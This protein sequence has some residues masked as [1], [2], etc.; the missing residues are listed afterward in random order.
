MSS[1]LYSNKPYLFKGDARELI[2]NKIEDNL[3]DLLITSP[4]YLNSRDYTDTY[5][6]ELRVLGYLNTPEEVR[7]LRSNTI[8]SHVQ[9]KWGTTRTVNSDTLIDTLMI[10]QNYE[11]TMWNKELINMIK[12]YFVD[13]DLLFSELHR[14]MKKR[15]TRIFLT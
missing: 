10:M 2:N 15:W 4:P 3:I 12:G 11:K 1:K 14:V 7:T 6:V 5:M 13:M 8:R 9:V